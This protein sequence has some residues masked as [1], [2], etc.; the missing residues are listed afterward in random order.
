[1]GLYRLL[2]SSTLSANG[3][4]ILP[5]FG[6]VLTFTLGGVLNP[7]IVGA[8]AGIGEA[9]GAIGAY[10]TGYAGKGIIHEIVTAAFTFASAILLTATVPKPFSSCQPY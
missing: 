7:A 4:F 3:T 6:I 9:I 8:V 2:L 5:G 10:Y 1:M